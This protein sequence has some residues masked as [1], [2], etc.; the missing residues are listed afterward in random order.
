MSL[1]TVDIFSLVTV[2]RLCYMYILYEC[3]DL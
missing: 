1:Q 2:D 3:A